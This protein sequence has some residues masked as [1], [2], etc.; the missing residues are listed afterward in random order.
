MT[1]SIDGAVLLARDQP[2]AGRSAAAD[3]VIEARHA[4]AAARRRPLAGPVREDL[5]ERLERR[6]H[7]LRR[8]V[9]PEVAHAGAVPLA[10]EE[11]ARVLVGQRHR[12]VRI[13]LVVAQPRVQRRP[14]A[15]DQLL[16]EQQRL[17][18]ARDDDRLDRRR[19]RD[20]LL[21]LAIAADAREVR[22]DALAQRGGLADV[23]HG[24]LAPC[25]R[26]TRPAHRATP[27]PARAG[28]WSV[29]R[30][31]RLKGTR[32]SRRCRLRDRAHRR[33]QA[34]LRVLTSS[35]LELVA[36]EHDENTDSERA[37]RRRGHE[38]A[39]R[40]CRPGRSRVVLLQARAPGAWAPARRPRPSS[41]LSQGRLARALRRGADRL[42]PGLPRQARLSRRA[43][44]RAT[45]TSW[46]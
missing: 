28:R 40:I 22:R 17:A 3:V 21:A 18:R 38:L 30:W 45:R 25:A 15:L 7:L 6:P 12:D 46:T 1:S 8:G 4:R 26:R 42:P 43:G 13:R 5:V 34:P 41:R 10:R 44:S 33:H 37:D 9:G 19:A 20:Q 23:E 36:W 29:L 16:L 35:A 2:H 11:H 32:A 24:A 27:A 14:V 39:G 31:P